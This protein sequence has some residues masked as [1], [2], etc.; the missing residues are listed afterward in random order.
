M[1]LVKGVVDVP[2]W[3]CDAASAARRGRLVHENRRRIDAEPGIEH[4]AGDPVAIA[5]QRGGPRRTTRLVVQRIVKIQDA[6]VRVGLECQ[7]QF[8]RTFRQTAETGVFDRRVV[9]NVARG[10]Y[11][12]VVDAR[13]QV[14]FDMRIIAEIIIV[15]GYQLATPALFSVQSEYRI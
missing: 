14:E 3:R 8:V 12:H 5:V 15:P 6:A 9:I 2:E 11:S 13:L 1:G 7:A 4:A 10:R